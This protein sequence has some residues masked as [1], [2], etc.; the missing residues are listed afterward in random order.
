MSDENKGAL[1]ELDVDLK[2]LQAPTATDDVFG[3]I[4][5]GSQFLPRLQLFTMSSNEVKNGAHH[6]I[7][8]YAVVRGKDNIVAVGKE[9]PCFPLSWRPKAVQFCKDGSVLSKYVKDDP[10]F[11]RIAEL[12]QTSNSGC[13]YGPEFLLW[14]PDAKCFVTFFMGSVSSRIEAPNMKSKLDEQRAALLTST[15]LSNKKGTWQAPVIKG[16]ST[17]FEVPDGEVIRAEVVK[18]QNPPKDEVEAATGDQRAR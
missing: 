17:P 5:Q 10:E 12:S 15:T 11:K 14:L 6:L 2:A 3:A 13:M 7:N 16:N 18:F 9:V 1:V 4:A 8:Q